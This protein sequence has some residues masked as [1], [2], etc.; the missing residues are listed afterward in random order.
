MHKPCEAIAIT[1]CPNHLRVLGAQ[2]P[3]SVPF[4]LWTYGTKSQIFFTQAIYSS[5]FIL[6]RAFHAMIIFLIMEMRSP[7]LPGRLFPLPVSDS[8]KVHN[9]GWFTLVQVAMSFP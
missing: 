3:C 9:I 2:G 7:N 5:V 6:Q 8:C 4:C 1:K